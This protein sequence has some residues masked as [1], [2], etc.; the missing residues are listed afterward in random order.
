MRGEL[1]SSISGRILTVS[2]GD[3]GR[4]RLSVRFEVSRSKLQ[5]HCDTVANATG[6]QIDGTCYRTARV[7]KAKVTGVGGERAD[8]AGGVSKRESSLRRA[9]QVFL[10]RFFLLFF[11]LFFEVF[12]FLFF[13]PRESGTCDISGRWEVAENDG[14]KS[15][16]D[17]DDDDEIEKSDR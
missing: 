8:E 10:L 16:R 15:Y 1:Q 2:G 5:A 7:D 9:F 12:L 3:S 11:D 13:L 14:R 6:Q 17:D 4:R